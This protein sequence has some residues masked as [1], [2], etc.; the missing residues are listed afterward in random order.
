MGLYTFIKVSTGSPQN[1]RSAGEGE[2]TREKSETEEL[3][4]QERS[5]GPKRQRHRTVKWMW[6]GGSDRKNF[7]N[8]A[9]ESGLYLLISD[10][11]AG[12]FHHES[13]M[14]LLV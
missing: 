6:T 12:L 10:S 13:D 4:R 11:H 8:P 1:G 5:K 14:G 2:Y 9:E 3:G 7:E